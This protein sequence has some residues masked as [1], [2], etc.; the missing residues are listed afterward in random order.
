MRPIR[1]VIACLAACAAL[2]TVSTTAFA[3]EFESLLAE[4]LSENVS[5]RQAA[6]SLR[7]AELRVAQLDEFFVPY[8]SIGFADAT[9]PQNGITY[10]G[11]EGGGL[12]NFQ[13]QPAVRFE[14]VL[15]A[16]ISLGLPMTVRP[17]PGEEQDAF[18]V[19]DPTLSV[20][21]RI[22]EETEASLLS[23]RAALVRARDAER[24][25]YADA[26]IQLVSEVFEAR[27]ALRT[28]VDTRTRLENAK[29]LLAVS[30]DETAARNLTRQILS[31]E[32][33]VVQAERSLRSIDSRV[34]SNAD[35]LHAEVI[36]RFDDWTRSLPTAEAKP[37]SS[38][39]IEA[40]RLSLAAAEARKSV[41]F[42]PYVPNPTLSANLSYDRDQN[43]LDWR[44]GLQFSVT[45][46]DRGERAVA[47]LERR[48]NA[49]IERLRLDAALESLD[50]SVTTAW[51]D[52]TILELDREIH[53]IDLEAQRETTKTTQE[54]FGH[55]FVTNEALTASELALS[56]AELQ[57]E[58]TEN[59]YRI[60]QLRVLRFF[61]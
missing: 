44:L 59:N 43:R 57:L 4:R 37:D 36:A 34:V 50:R 35:A 16:S 56:A 42:L 21:R 12:Q 28:L 47:S 45:I 7:Q 48:E 20:S 60:Q 58:R 25:A 3:A 13:I 39:T 53:R 17:S 30:R 8:A 5:Y 29:K 33:A 18:S 11:G 2:F 19:G 27:L 52:L 46:L 31:A 26:R 15:G 54:L 55:G 9:R 10:V 32:R 61:D 22:F 23:A 1:R 49:T 6:L 40:Q 14:N 51:E 24:G 38:A 41:S